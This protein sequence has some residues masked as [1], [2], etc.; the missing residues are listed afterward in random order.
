MAWAALRASIF[1]AC[2]SQSRREPFRGITGAGPRWRGARSG[3]SGLQELLHVLMRS[4]IGAWLPSVASMPWACFACAS[5]R[6]W[7]SLACLSV[8]S[9]MV[10]AGSWAQ[11]GL[12]QQEAWMDRG[13]IP[14]FVAHG[15]G[16][17]CLIEFHHF[18]IQ[19][20]GQEPHC[21]NTSRGYQRGLAQQEAWW[22][23]SFLLTA[24][25]LSTAWA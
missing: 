6:A 18:D 5:F 12:A 9:P 24:S 14:P 21:V 7:S 23:P 4:S 3:A 1:A 10:L 22:R 19:S 8:E 15:P 2:L 16:S 25:S 17:A 11:R 13:L 20:T